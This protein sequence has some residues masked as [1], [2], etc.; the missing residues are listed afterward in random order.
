MRF[1]R[2]VTQHV[3]RRPVAP[4]RSFFINPI[5]ETAESVKAIVESA[6]KSYELVMS[7]ASLLKDYAKCANIQVRKR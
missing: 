5:K 2:L 3:I 1:A 4:I 7:T 6:E